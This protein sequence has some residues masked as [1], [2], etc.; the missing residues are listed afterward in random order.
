MSGPAAPAGWYP[1]PELVNTR[2]YWDGERWT[3]HRQEAPA[4]T[5]AV[6]LSDTEYG[7][8]PDP[9]SSGSR[10]GRTVA[11]LA[12]ALLV[13]FFVKTCSGPPSEE[14]LQREAEFGAQ[15][16]CQTFVERRLKAPGTADFHDLD[17]TGKEPNF[18]VTGTVDSENSFGAKLRNAFEC[19]VTH[20]DGDNYRL[21]DLALTEN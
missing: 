10:T 19:T 15:D 5:P 20:T 11:L 1:D 21:V 12:A 18:V 14:A 16:V 4:P 13:V 3:E 9:P 17:A 2:R 7:H 6:P 8:Q